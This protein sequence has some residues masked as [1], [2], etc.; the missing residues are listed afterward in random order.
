MPIASLSPVASTS[1]VPGRQTCDHRV[2]QTYST[3]ATEAES[4]VFPQ[5]QRAVFA[6]RDRER[7]FPTD[8]AVEDDTGLL[9]KGLDV[10]NDTNASQGTVERS[11]FDKGLGL[12]E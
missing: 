11:D 4:G 3:C 2:L 1:S 9:T 5:R 12:P 10:K 7:C 8:S 6:H